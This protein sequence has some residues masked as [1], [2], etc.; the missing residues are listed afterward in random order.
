MA[1]TVNWSLDGPGKLSATSGASVTYSPPAD[2]VR[3]NTPVLVKASAGDVSQAYRLTLYPDPGAPGL[4]LITGTLGSIGKLDGSGADARFSDISALAPTGILSVS[5]SPEDIVYLLAY[6]AGQN[7]VLK[8]LADGST[9]PFLSAAQVRRPGP[10]VPGRRCPRG[11]G[12]RGRQP[13]PGRP[14]NDTACSAGAGASAHLGTIE[15]AVPDAGGNL[16]LQSCASVRKMTPAGVVPPLAGRLGP[17]A[18][19]ADQMADGSGTAPAAL[20]L[21][22]AGPGSF[23]LLSGG[24]ILKLVLPH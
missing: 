22:P 14:P 1:A 15:D 13:P 12:Q 8:L 7:V 19:N 10:A 4:R 3:A 20:S 6:R 24:A 16:L 11:A 2:G 18:V 17:V 21:A 5:V 23:V 9:V